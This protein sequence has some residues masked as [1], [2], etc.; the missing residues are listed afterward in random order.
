MEYS[1]YDRATG[2]VSLDA[3]SGNPEGWETQ[4]VLSKGLVDMSILKGEDIDVGN[5]PDTGS[6]PTNKSTFSATLRS[7]KTVVVPKS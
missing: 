2:M 5:R 6:T 1:V 7:Q 3:D 4:E